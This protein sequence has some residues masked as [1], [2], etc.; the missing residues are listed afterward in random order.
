MKL[1]LTLC[2]AALLSCF[3]L[4]S[5]AALPL[6]VANVPIRLALKQDPSAIAALE[7]ALYSVSDPSSK[8]Y[9]LHLSALQ[10]GH[11][12]GRSHSE[13]KRITNWL[14]TDPSLGVLRGSVRVHETRDYIDV[15]VPESTA[16]EMVG[17]HLARQRD[18]SRASAGI[19]RFSSHPAAAL[20]DFAIHL[21]QKH[22]QA[23][24]LSAESES[25]YANWQRLPSRA[26]RR[27]RYAIDHLNKQ[28]AEAKAKHAGKHGRVAAP[29]DDSGT[30][31][32]QRAAYGVPASLTCT[33]PKN[34]QMVWGT[35]TY[36]FTPSDLQSYYSQ[37]N[38]PASEIN[39]L[40]VTDYPG[41]EG[42]DNWGEGTLDIS[43]ISA[44]APGILTFVS[45]TDNSE[46]AE[47]GDGF[48]P[49]ML[50]WM[51]GLIQ[52][53]STQGIPNVISLSLGSLSWDSCNLLCEGVAAESST[54]YAQCQVRC[55][56]H[57]SG[58]FCCVHETTG[59]RCRRRIGFFL[60][61][62]GQWRAV[63]VGT[64]LTHRSSCLL[65]CLS[66]C[67]LPPPQSYMQQ[68]RQVCMYPD[69]AGL[70]RMNVEFAKLGTMGVT[71][72]AATGDGGSHFSF[73]FFG[74]DPIGTLL[75]TVRA[76]T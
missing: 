32:N 34:R 67:V 42:G 74:S 22:N 33:N 1:V 6:G 62:R 64:S 55:P 28:K 21:D 71:V 23:I 20:I 7:A 29:N 75:N 50:A 8:Q 68:Q 52:N 13:I 4:A 5:S 47:E 10:I 39:L 66:V 30:P 14:K 17:D 53:A 27:A 45:N 31:A 36:G 73:Q 37:M 58:L 18:G 69:S 76:H 40:E 35:G 26:E 12:I 2:L 48:G 57:A 46:G 70:D 3:A 15:V 59:V 11:I 24:R 54:T 43:L 9:G 65:D 51:T 25:E 19:G 41:V 49:A 61:Q 38:I 44:I 60:H 63:L 56:M 72:M 16:K